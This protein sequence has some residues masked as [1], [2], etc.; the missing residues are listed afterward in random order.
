ALKAVP[1][2]LY[3]V[4]D[5]AEASSAGKWRALALEAIQ[6]A[7]TLG[8]TPVLTGGTGLYFR[9]LLGGL[10]DIPPIPDAAREQTQALYE[11]LGEEEFRKRLKKLDPSSAKRLAKNDRQRLVRAYEVAMHTGQPLSHW[12]HMASENALEGFEIE[13][14]LLMPDREQ[15]YAAC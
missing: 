13:P 12:H 11:E 14:H 4:T 9:S 15:L 1:H 8:R 3:G 6:Q 7:L 10:A 5:P 2:R